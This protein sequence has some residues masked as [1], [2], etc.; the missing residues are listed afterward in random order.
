M[1]DKIKHLRSWGLQI[2]N[3]LMSIDIDEHKTNLFT[4]NEIIHIRDARPTPQKGG[5]APLRPVKITKTWGVQQGKVDFNPLKFGRQL[6]G[7]IQ[8]CP[9]NICLTH[10]SVDFRA[11]LPCLA[12]PRRLSPLPRP[13]PSGLWAPPRAS[14]V[15]ICIISPSYILNHGDCFLIRTQVFFVFVLKIFHRNYY[16]N[17][18]TRH[19]CDHDY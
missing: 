8:F 17:H 6:Q 1:T 12:P 15:H 2:T 14:L 19:Q 4:P 7:R 3:W 10:K 5:F 13:T 11:F 18:Q 16:C 9:I